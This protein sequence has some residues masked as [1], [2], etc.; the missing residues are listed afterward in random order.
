MSGID[1]VK[2]DKYFISVKKT[3]KLKNFKNV[4]K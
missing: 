1:H 2:N 3:K 4:K